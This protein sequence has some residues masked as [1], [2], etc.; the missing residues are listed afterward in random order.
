MTFV[1]VRIAVALFNYL[2]C[3]VL[4]LLILFSTWDNPGISTLVRCLCIWIT[5]VAVL[6]FIFFP[7]LFIGNNPADRSLSDTLPKHSG[8]RSGSESSFQGRS[9]PSL[10]GSLSSHDSLRSSKWVDQ[11]EKEHEIRGSESD[12]LKAKNQRLE[13]EL[14][15]I[16]ERNLRLEAEQVV[17]SKWIDELEKEKEQAHRNGLQRELALLKEKDQRL[18]A[19]ILADSHLNHTLKV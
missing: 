1:V 3:F 15:V 9:E 7:K 8:Y 6:A 19:E 12:I 16:E 11:L 14:K 5:N 18:E 10:H 2:E 4:C 13:A 17:Q